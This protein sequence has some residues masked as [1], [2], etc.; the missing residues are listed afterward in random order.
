[1]L[2][3]LVAL[4]LEDAIRNQIE[5]ELSNVYLCLTLEIKL[6]ANS[7][8]DSIKALKTKKV[9]ESPDMCREI[10]SYKIVKK[11][12]DRSLKIE[13][14]EKYN[15]KDCLNTDETDFIRLDF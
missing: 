12:Q 15:R 7:I 10:Y 9:D 14:I 6:N 5:D 2:S 8:S 11:L 4:V 1:M 13:R 3:Y